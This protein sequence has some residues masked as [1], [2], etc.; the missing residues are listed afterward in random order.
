MTAKMK[1][2]TEADPLQGFRRKRSISG[3]SG[4]SLLDVP[5][6]AAL[7]KPCR[8]AASARAQLPP[9]FEVWV[10]GAVSPGT[11]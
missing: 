10:I 11:S 6:L 5:S 2:M 9:G 4:G 3:P 1:P 7:Q 8:A